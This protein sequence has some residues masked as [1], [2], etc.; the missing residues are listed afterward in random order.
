MHLLAGAPGTGKTIL[1]STF[2][3]NAVTTLKEKAVYATFE[4]WTEY[5][6]RNMKKL[7]I[8]L[9]A[10]EKA[11]KLKVVDLDALKGKELESNI[12][13]LLLAGKE[14]KRSILVIDSL[15]ALLLATESEFDLSAFMKW[16]YKP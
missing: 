5:L 3:Y 9:G 1:A 12:Q 4:E 2:A 15:T 7:G 6:Q 11:G 10:A 13:L 16:I 8:D 14:T